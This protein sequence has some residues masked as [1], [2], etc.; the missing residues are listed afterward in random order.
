[1]PSTWRGIAALALAASTLPGAA[2]RAQSEPS[3]TF[4]ESVEV[5]VVNVDVAVTDRDGRPVDD[6]ERVDFLLEVDGKPVEISNFARVA[7]ASAPPPPVPAPPAAPAST[8]VVDESTR[9]RLAVWIDDLHMLPA[10]RNRVLR[11]LAPLL[12]AQHA[13]GADV[14]LGRFDRSFQLVRNFGASAPLADGLATLEARAAS[15]VFGAAAR[16]SAFD[17]ID[18]I[19]ADDE[20]ERVDDMVGAALRYA[21]PLR[22]DSLLA[23]NALRGAMRALAGLPGRRAL[24][25]VADGVPLVPGQEAFLYI[26]QLCAVQTASGAKETL[27]DDL[28]RLAAEANAAG[29]TFYTLQASG[30][31]VGG[32]A[33]SAGPGLDAVNAFAA[34]ANLSDPMHQLASATGGR[35]L[36]ESN[37]LTPLIEGLA[38][39]LDSGYSLGFRPAGE[40]ADG[41]QHR[42]D[43]KVRRPGLRVRH[44][45]SFRD[46][47]PEEV[48]EARL[49]AALRHG[50]GVNALG[51][52]LEASVARDAKGGGSVLPVRVVVPASAVLFLG[53]PGAALAR[54]EI[55]LAA[56]DESG[57]LS[58]IRTTTVTVERAKLPASLAAAQLRFPLDLG[59]RKG[60]ARLAALV[61]DLAAQTDSLVWAEV[62]VR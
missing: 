3:G 17:E 33:E 7:R 27:V 30:L 10:R 12:E 49:L 41:K 16:R 1:M 56:S 25:Y 62:A 2:A 34:R 50:G 13:A 54:L 52:S 20:C 45:E 53:A 8:S 36:L 15:G 26:D 37:R 21:Q 11:E 46:R 61:R 19:F 14:L 47:M 29:V 31:P 35:A 5:R 60:R 59:L 43:V 58:P 55:S 39:D 57:G 38:R 4:G 24:L 18:A 42:I 51:V 40:G 9:L 23:I 44:R 22:H 32:S 48:R 6:L 28:S